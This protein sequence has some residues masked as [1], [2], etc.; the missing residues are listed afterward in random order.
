MKQFCQI[1]FFIFFITIALTGYISSSFALISGFIIT[2]IFSNP[3]PE[4]TKKAT[5]ILLK[6]SVIGLG[7]GMSLTETIQ[8]SK[9]GL[10]LTTLSIILTVILGLFFSK[11]FTIDKKIGFLITSGTSICGGSAIAAISPVIKASHKTISI[12]IGVV[13]FLNAIALFIFPPLGH[14]LGL[15]QKQFGIWCAIAIHD[16]S[17]VVGAALEYGDEALQ[18]ATTVK[19]ARTL[20]V[21]PLSF[22]A[23]F[24][25]KSDDRKIKIPYFII[26]FIIAMLLNSYQIV[27][28]SF[29]MDI[30][31]LSK[32]LLVATLFLVGMNLTIKDLKESG[33][34]P[35]IFASLLWTFISVFSLLFIIIF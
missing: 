35:I 22:F 30:V 7:F 21:I 15:T 8:T 18:I 12:A 33:I 10:T 4:K 19:L 5:Q 3:F 29:S 32:R 1:S 23:M 2:Y 20:W 13:F 6:I 28:E 14:I 24:L 34:K 9:E 26:G 11:L 25:F 31:E 27:P 17:S 16:T